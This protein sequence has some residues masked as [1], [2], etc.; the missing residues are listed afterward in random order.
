M[1]SNCA[2]STSI[3]CIFCC[4][5]C[6]AEKLQNAFTFVPPPPSYEVKVV[7]LPLQSGPGHELVLGAGKLVYTCPS[8]IS[9]ASY[10]QAAERA[11]VRF[12][13]TGLGEQIPIVW[14][15]RIDDAPPGRKQRLVLLHCHG[16]ATD[17]GIMMRPFC[18]LSKQLGM[19]IVGLEYTGYGV[20][21]GVPSV[22]SSLQ[23]A[24]AA[25]AYLVAA[26]VSPEQIVVYGQSVG[27]G[28][29]MHLASRYPLGGVILH[30]PMLSGIKVIDPQPD[31]GCR[32]SC[33]WCCFDF[34]PNQRYVKEIRCPVFVMHGRKDAIIPFYHGRRL[35][36]ATP[37]E[38]R[39]PGYFPM[40]AGHNDI[41]ELD[42]GTYFK[43]MR[44]FL[45]T[46]VERS[47]QMSDTITKPTQVTMTM[48]EEPAAGVAAEPNVGPQ[49][50]R[51]EKLRQGNLLAGT[52]GAV[53]ELRAK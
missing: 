28:P 18:Q 17:I 9:E 27:C 3:G 10:H 20:S 6:N 15:P 8:L 41:V 7:K 42:T 30:S 24:E 2:V 21:S 12:L 36:E 32:P 47:A 48:S 52:S 4:Q 26:G 44:E 25:Y 53:R 45:N 23:D 33:V 50:G 16:N 43:K 5:G 1:G 13:K 22:K 11:E 46:V 40:A 39:W 31:A 51:Y 49:D 19:D 34:Y 14:L 29:A 38:H 35:A 37:E